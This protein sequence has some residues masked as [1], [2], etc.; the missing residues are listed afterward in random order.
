MV[1]VPTPAVTGSKVPLEVLVIPFPLHVPPGS[2]ALSVTD[3]AL[4][5]NGPAGVIVAS[6]KV[7]IVSV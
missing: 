1:C 3:D 2:A 5:Q 6:S 7:V 4:S